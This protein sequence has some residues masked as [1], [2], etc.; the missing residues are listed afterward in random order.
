MRSGRGIY[1]TIG[2]AVLLESTKLPQ[3]IHSRRL[4]M[5]YGWRQIEESMIAESNHTVLVI[6]HRHPDTDAVCSALAYA[7]P[8]SYTHLDVYKR[9]A[10]KR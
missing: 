8:V 10:Q 6:G 4:R 3:A 9:Q 5:S 2:R 7:C 1:A